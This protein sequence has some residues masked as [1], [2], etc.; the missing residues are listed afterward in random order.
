MK[1]AEVHAAFLDHPHVAYVYFSATPE[2]TEASALADR[3]DFAKIEFTPPPSYCGAAYFVAENLVFAPEPFLDN[4]DGVLSI[5]RHGL[6]VIRDSITGER[7]IG[8]VRIAGGGIPQALLQND[9]VQAAL[10]EQL[11]TSAPNGRPWDIKVITNK[12]PLAWEDRI[13]QR[14]YRSDTDKN[15]LFFLFQTCTRGT[16]LKGWH[17]MLAFWHDARS[18]EFSNLNTLIQALLRTAHYSTMEGYRGPQP[19]RMYVDRLVMDYAADA[20]DLQSY[21]DAGGKQPTR[22]R[23]GRGPHRDYDI[24]ETAEF[25]DLAGF[26]GE[27]GQALPNPESYPLADGFHQIAGFGYK[28]AERMLRTWSHAD[29]VKRLRGMYSRTNFFFVPCYRDVSNP[30]TLVWLAVRLRDHQVQAPAGGMPIVATKGS[31]YAG[32]GRV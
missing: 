19:I 31:M 11:G 5:S 24:R 1:L 22:T 7:H 2:E 26:C 23:K 13:T 21:I 17:P 29:A 4:E 18:C 14:G 8:V 27:T 20:A 15:H 30:R 6:N 3:E 16:D 32:G 10:V 9:R 12:S 28:A 25:G